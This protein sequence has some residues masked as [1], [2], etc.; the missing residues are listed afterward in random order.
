MRWLKP[1]GRLFIARGQS[2]AM[3]ALV[4]TRSDSGRLSEQSLFD[5]DMPRLIGAEDVPVFNF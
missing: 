1:G 3:E 2:P 4:L 5:T